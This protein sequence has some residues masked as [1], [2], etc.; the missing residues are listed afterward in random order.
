MEY[1]ISIWYGSIEYGVS[2]LNLSS[3]CSCNMLIFIT[4]C[5]LLGKRFNTSH[6]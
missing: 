2:Y 3:D 5:I 1:G 6:S 4:L